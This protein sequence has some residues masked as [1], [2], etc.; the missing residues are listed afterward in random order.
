MVNLCDAFCVVKHFRCTRREIAV[1]LG[2][3]EKWFSKRCHLKRLLACERTI[4][5]DHV[6]PTGIQPILTVFKTG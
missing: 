3:N 2:F 4:R 5:V 6:G 1:N